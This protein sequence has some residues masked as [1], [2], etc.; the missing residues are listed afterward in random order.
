MT[1]QHQ[2][3]LYELL[4]AIYRTRDAERGEP[5]RAL[6]AVIQQ[7]VD[8]LEADMD[9]LYD[10]WFVETAEEWLLPYLADLLG[11]RMPHTVESAGVFSL[12]A[13]VAN[14]LQYRQRKGTA[15][16][17]EQL[18]DDITGWEARVVEFYRLLATTQ[19]LNH[20]RPGNVHTPNLRDTNAL[21]LLDT[22]FDAAAHTGEVRR[23][24]PRQGRYNIP[25]IGLFLWRLQNY[26]VVD[27][28]PRRLPGFAEPRYTFSPLGIDSPLF[29]NPA[30]EQQVEQ[31]AGEINVPGMLRRRA[32]ADP[33]RQDHYF[34]A[35]PVI[36]VLRTPS[37]PGAKPARVPADAIEVCDLAD[38]RQ[39]TTPGKD[40]AVDPERGRLTYRAGLDVRAL[41]VRYSYGFSADIGGGPYDRR[42]S[43]A[44]PREL[45]L[46]EVAKGTTIATLQ[47]ALTAWQAAG[48]PPAVIRVMDNEVYGGTLDL[49][50]PAQGRLWIEAANRRNPT[51]RTVGNSSIRISAVAAGAA[52]TL[53]GL[54][55]EGA[56]EID[57][58]VTLNLLDCTLVPGRSLQL[59]G[60]PRSPDRDS[61]RVASSAATVLIERSILG[62]IRMP[63][64]SEL[65]ACDAIVL[66]HPAAGGPRPAI[67]G[68]D[69]VALDDPATFGPRTRLARATI[70]GAVV[71]TEFDV[72]SDVIFNDPVWSERRQTGCLRFSH[73]PPGSRTPRR[74]RCQPDLALSGI[75]DA[76]T[77]SAIARRLRPQYASVRYGEPDF[78]QLNR[79]C[80]TEIRSGAEDGAEMGAFQQLRQPQREANL[81][82]ALEE[83][84]PFGLQ[85]G[86]FFVT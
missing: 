14:T 67:S 64:T 17:L 8:R 25:N 19:H 41:H 78:A 62:P 84:L 60:S 85:A 2:E 15:A 33:A 48:T 66:A 77:R 1:E 29:N 82:A 83:Y 72:V 32:V 40:V 71:V 68:A 70:F 50:L 36:A 12:R 56:L 23:I 24:V 61:L 5:L 16:V 86:L 52:L 47:A 45:L 37:G 31:I 22:P 6:L 80:A 9:G 27:G 44:D 43:L 74:H 4:P 63:R 21:E 35:Q 11:V 34:G 3:R 46:I 79:N 28:V 39:P 49:T 59:D 7:E 13:Y 38:W 81:H 30:P 10:N 55:I 65:T 57:S 75:E 58:D 42:N 26:P 20:L 73:V 76:N 53:S 51:V 69:V 54:W 18:A